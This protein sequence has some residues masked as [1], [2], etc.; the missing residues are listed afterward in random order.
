MSILL[1]VLIAVICTPGLLVLIGAILRKRR[2]PEK[3]LKNCAIN[4][5]LIPLRWFKYG[6]FKSGKITLEKAMKYAVKKTGL[7]DFGNADFVAN[8]A[9]VL[10]T[11]EHQKLKLTNLGYIMYRIEMNMTMVR[12][13]KLIQYM[14]DVP[15]VAQVSVR[16]PVFVMGLPRTGTT[17]LHRLLSLDP[18][19][20]SPLLWELMAPV[21][22]AHPQTP[23]EVRTSDMAKDNSKRRKFVHKLIADRQNMGD[24]ALQ[25]IHEIGADLPEECIL[26]LTDELPLHMSLLYSCYV[27]WE[28]YFAIASAKVAA[29]YAHYKQVLQL[30]SFQADQGAAPKRWVLKCPAHLYYTKEIAK[31]F[32][33]AKIVWTHRHPV[34]AVPSLCSLVKSLFQVYYENESRSDALLGRKVRDLSSR[35]LLECDKDIKESGLPCSHIHYE[36]LIRDPVGVVKKIYANNNWVFSDAYQTVLQEYLKDN[37]EAREKKKGESDVL[38]DYSPEEFSLTADELS[39]GNFAEYVKMFDVPMSRN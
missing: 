13:L 21:P 7:T 5:A 2:Y 9:A 31:V 33:D 20:R 28:S 6:P 14:K 1:V 32:P 17:F 26:A 10:D 29:A 30:L 24:H 27:N 35:F 19:V 34:S 8:Y 11:E 22:A 4:V 15:A 23:E 39:A 36:D 37:K 3:S 25:H 18:E 38:H 16:E 12:R